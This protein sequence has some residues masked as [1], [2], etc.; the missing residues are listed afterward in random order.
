MA[1][2]TDDSSTDVTTSRVASP[3]ARWSTALLAAAFV[4][5]AI[6]VG[7][8]G[9][10]LWQLV[11][12]VLVGALAA[13]A[14]VTVSRLPERSV[15]WLMVMVGLVV[16]PAGVG[17]VP[18]VVEKPASLGSV[19]A[20]GAVVSGASLVVLGT[21]ARTRGRGRLRRAGAGLGTLVAAAIV[22]FVVGP[23][24]AV[25]NVPRPEVSATPASVGLAYDDVTLRTADGVDLAGWFVPAVNGA[26]VV[27]LHGAGSTRSDVLPEAEILAR[28]GFGVL[29]VDARGHGESGGRAMD[30][31]WHGDADIAAAT[32]FLAERDD[33]EPGGIGVVGSSMGGEEAIGASA[34]NRLIRAV[35]A[36]GA[37]A[38]TAADKGWMSDQYG[39][40]GLLQEQIE[41]MQYWLTDVLTAASPPTSLR[42]AVRESRTTPYLL[43]TAGA[44]PDEAHAAAYIAGAAPDRVET[45]NVEG[46][47]H[48]EGLAVSPAEW[49]H[50]VITFLAGALGVRVEA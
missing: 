8:D 15:G 12:V 3:P 17:F 50:R 28:H 7:R 18:Y 49:E 45:W 21:V 33:V 36:E 24:V 5:L 46:A 48:T 2:A 42:T 35:V 23:A 47:A 11:R 29:L 13:A 22:T 6:M 20:I 38:R 27:L 40:R 37:T 32:A 14:F 10:V 39:V 16:L 43:I 1:I 9:D 41:R 44:V 19:A 4:A 34:S 30:F 31:G 26:A 25:T